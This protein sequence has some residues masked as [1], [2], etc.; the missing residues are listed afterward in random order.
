MTARKSEARSYFPLTSDRAD[1]S[2]YYTRV[3]VHFQAKD[4]F[5]MVRS[6][7]EVDLE[8]S[9]G[10]CTIKDVVIER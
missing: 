7:A 3:E 6:T 10:T 5:A 2:S 4:D 8:E 9:S 1:G